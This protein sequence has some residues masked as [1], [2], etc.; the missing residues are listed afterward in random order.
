PFLAMKL[1][2]GRTLAA[3]L[4]ARSSPADELPRFIQAFEQICQAVG[5]AHAGGIIHRDLKPA[6]VM[7]GAF[8]EVQ[9]MDWGLAKDLHAA[10]GE[11]V[12]GATVSSGQP[13][14]PAQP[15]TNQNPSQTWDATPGRSETT[16]PGQVLG[17]VSYMAPEQARG[18][19]DCRSDVFSL[20]GILC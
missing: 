5:F 20:G 19:A 18:S 12:S 9:V 4:K 15:P 14:R 1:I 16:Q 2:R 3:L 13:R 6:N 8:G 10:K 17:T 11:T 7:I